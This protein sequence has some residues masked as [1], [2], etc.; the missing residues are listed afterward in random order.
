[1]L[2]DRTQ[3]TDARPLLRVPF[4]RRPEE[5]L[6]CARAAEP[7]APVVLFV[8]GYEQ[9]APSTKSAWSLAA[10]AQDAGFAFASVQ[11]DGEVER[12]RKAVEHLV[13]HEVLGHDRERV[14]VAGH[15]RGATLA[16][17]LATHDQRPAGFALISGRYDVDVTDPSRPSPL[18]QLGS[19]PADCLV[20]W[21]AHDEPDV[22]RQ[23]QVWATK[24]ALSHWNRLAGAVEADGRHH[25]DV[26]DDLF[27]DRTA[28]GATMRRMVRSPRSVTL[29]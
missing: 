5:S 11:H 24:W 1:M 22:R 27:D 18:S 3:C 20:G 23:S 7:E 17:I 16:A 8:H 28:L 4:G 29:H 19:S 14:Y 9:H 6:W 15:G 26:L 21:A 10:A 13:T 12:I 2:A 25:C